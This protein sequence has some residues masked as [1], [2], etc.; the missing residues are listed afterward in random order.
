VQDLIGKG[1]VTKNYSQ[2]ATPDCQR[3]KPAQDSRVGLH[4]SQVVTRPMERIFID[5][6]GPIVRSRNGNVALFV[7]LDGFS[8]FVSL[9]PVR[10]ISSDVKNCL[11]ENIFFRPMESPRLFSRTMLLSSYRGRFITCAFHGEFG[12]LPPRLIIPRHPRSN[13]SIET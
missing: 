11:V 12:T 13:V 8:K 7:V 6:V 9:Y 2:Y 5:F 10:R 3:A 1:V 4:S